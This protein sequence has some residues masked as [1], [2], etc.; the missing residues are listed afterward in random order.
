MLIKQYICFNT[1]NNIYLQMFLNY[2][3][4]DYV[5]NP[6][7]KNW[8]AGQIQSIIKNKVTANFENVGRSFFSN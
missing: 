4:G 7:N 2:E 1:Y 3:P 6:N 5:I 8:G